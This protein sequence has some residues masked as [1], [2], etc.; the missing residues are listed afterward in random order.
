MAV[1]AMCT[2]RVAKGSNIFFMTEAPRSPTSEASYYKAHLWLLHPSHSSSELA[3]SLAGGTQS[4]FFGRWRLGLDG[5]RTH[6]AAFWDY[7]AEW[8]YLERKQYVFARRLDA[9][10]GDRGRSFARS[11]LGLQIRRR[12]GSARVLRVPN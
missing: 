3:E 5:R 6:L 12:R 9:A 10:T 2:A 11:K 7:I 1:P 4:G 8:C